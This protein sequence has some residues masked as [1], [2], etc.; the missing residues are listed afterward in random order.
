[1][2]LEV[3]FNHISNI[4]LFFLASIFTFKAI[5]KIYV[6]YKD[7]QLVITWCCPLF[8]TSRLLQWLISFLISCAPALIARFVKQRINT[9][10]YK[11]TELLKKFYVQFTVSFL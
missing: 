4:S 11:K 9:Y 2:V 7:S 1:M 5:I 6:K 3:V 8:C 10:F